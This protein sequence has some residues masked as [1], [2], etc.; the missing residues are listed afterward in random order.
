[1]SL[2][3]IY[4]WTV[5]LVNKNFENSSKKRGH[6]VLSMAANAK[7]YDGFMKLEERGI[8]AA[9]RSKCVEP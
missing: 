1:M 5:V 9:S 7:T 6:R 3:C 8:H 4:S 2:H